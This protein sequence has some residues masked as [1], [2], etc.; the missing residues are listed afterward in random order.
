MNI[1]LRHLQAL[2]AI[3]D[4][5]SI[6]AA[7]A[8]LH[9]AQPALSRTLSQLEDRVGTQLVERTTRSLELTASGQLLWEKAH[10]ILQ[11]VDEAV[12]EATAGPAPLRV[13]YAWSALGRHTVALLRTWKDECPGTALTVR[14]MDNPEL[15]MRKGEIDV[16]FLR[17]VSGP[18][19]FDHVLLGYEKRL[20][21]VAADDVLSS[22]EAL[23]LSDL[24]SRRLALCA[25]AGTADLELWPPD[26]RPTQTLVVGNVDEW[27][28]AIAAGEAIGLT[29][30]ATEY[31]HP[32]PGVSYASLP[33]VEPVPVFLT[34]SRLNPHPK[35]G[36]FVTHAGRILRE[37]A[38]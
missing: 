37:S 19:D 21:A 29:S 12:K 1:E 20:V 15:A 11:S 33:G 3:G 32:H 13:G 26:Q 9:V 35:V 14:Q 17:S 7:A 16:A 36:Q 22:R 4:Q 8:A 10:R 6:T 23:S 2:A 31:S 25:T 28:T 34:W 27:L 30:E 38:G 5:G 24:S 18:A